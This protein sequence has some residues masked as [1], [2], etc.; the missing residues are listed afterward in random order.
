MITAIFKKITAIRSSINNLWNPSFNNLCN[1]GGTFVTPY[2]IIGK[3]V[4]MCGL[5]FLGAFALIPATLLLTVSFFVLFAI[6][7]AET[8][9]LK[10]FG[11][12]I[13]ALLWVCATLAFSAGIYAIATGRHPVCAEM[14]KMMKGGMEKP[15]MP[16][17]MTKR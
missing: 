14:H 15:M 6:R 2:C 12:V 7:K 3:E 4:C 1:Q 5:K 9:G 16:Q 10:V 17:P 13:A 8:G 11:Y